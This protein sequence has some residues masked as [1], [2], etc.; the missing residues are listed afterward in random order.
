[1]ARAAAQKAEVKPANT[2]NLSPAQQAQVDAAEALH[3][4]VD[5]LVTG[6]ESGEK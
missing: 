1:M 6:N 3:A 4:K 2:E 5:T